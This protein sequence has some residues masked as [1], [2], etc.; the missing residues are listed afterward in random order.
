[1]HLHTVKD[2]NLAYLVAFLHILHTLNTPAYFAYLDILIS[3]ACIF[4]YYLSVVS[5]LAPYFLRPLSQGNFKD[6]N[7]L[8]KQ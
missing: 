1:M 8:G 5:I 7:I 4:S 6:S 3:F 2:A